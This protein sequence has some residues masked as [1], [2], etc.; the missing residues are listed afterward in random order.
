[1][2][3][4]IDGAAFATGHQPVTVMK[5]RPF[6]AAVRLADSGGQ[7]FFQVRAALRVRTM[8]RPSSLPQ[9]EGYRKSP[10]SRQKTEIPK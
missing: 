3:N 4:G 9:L 5:Y 1:M 2:R 8:D 7:S 6:W 10:S